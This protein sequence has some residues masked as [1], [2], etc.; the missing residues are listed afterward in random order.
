MLYD[1]RDLICGSFSLENCTSSVRAINI[2][3]W[4]LLMDPSLEDFRAQPALH[5]EK[6][7]LLV[8]SLMGS[9]ADHSTLMLQALALLSF[10]KYKELQICRP[11]SHENRIVV[12]SL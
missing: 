12:R 1:G 2:F 10:L 5:F 8:F 9:F 7:T 6:T 11:F 3:K 4:S